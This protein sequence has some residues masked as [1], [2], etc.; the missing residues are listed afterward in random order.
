MATGPLTPPYQLPP[1]EDARRQYVE[2]MAFEP[3]LADL[4]GLVAADFAD[5]SRHQ[6]RPLRP[7][8]AELTATS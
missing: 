5:K 6:P 3:W 1:I 8:E 4:V 7:R 2:T